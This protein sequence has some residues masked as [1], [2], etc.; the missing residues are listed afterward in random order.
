M[1]ELRRRRRRWRRVGEGR[2]ESWRGGHCAGRGWEGP[3]G[4]KEGM[5]KRE[6]RESDAFAVEMEYGYLVTVRV[7]IWEKATYGVLQVN[8]DS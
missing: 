1:T 4:R 3:V 7:E 5:L 8:L 6:V 2:G